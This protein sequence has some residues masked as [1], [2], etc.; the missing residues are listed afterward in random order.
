MRNHCFVSLSF[1]LYLPGASGPED[2][3]LLSG[4]SSL[5][6]CGAAAGGGAVAAAAVVVVAA[7]AEYFSC[8]ASCCRFRT[9]PIV[10][11]HTIPSVV[12]IH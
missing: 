5:Q 12:N 2:K 10:T 7:A 11:Q 3:Y 4:F 1:A 9:V 8:S 6:P